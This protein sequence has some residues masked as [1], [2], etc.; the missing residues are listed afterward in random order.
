LLMR[1]D[2]QCPKQ[3]RRALPTRP[4][5]VIEDTISLHTIYFRVNNINHEVFA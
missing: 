1:G 5:T 4:L 2:R 3:R